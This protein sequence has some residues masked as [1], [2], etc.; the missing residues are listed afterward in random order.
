[1]EE[2]LQARETAVIVGAAGAAMVIFAVPSFAESSVEAALTLSEPED[3]TV[4]G[5]V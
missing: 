5:A 4:E 3:G 2:G 1:M